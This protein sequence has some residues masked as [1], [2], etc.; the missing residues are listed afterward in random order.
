MA[1]NSDV[2]ADLLKTD[3]GADAAGPGFLDLPRAMHFWM[4]GEWPMLA[5][6]DK[7][8]I[9][10]DRDRGLTA[11][12]VAA[13]HHFCDDQDAARDWSRIALAWGCP[14][15]YLL[16]VLAAGVEITV[17]R[18]AAITG[19]IDRARSRMALSAKPVPGEL[20]QAHA[21][22]R[23]SKELAALGLLNESAEVIGEDLEKLLE[24]PLGR[25]ARHR[26]RILKSE[27][28]QVRQQ[29]ALHVA[30]GQLDS[31]PSPDAESAS[32]ADAAK[33]HSM[34]QLG[35][36][37]WVLEHTG[38]KRG[39]YFVEFG[40]T[41]GV[42]L[43]NTFLLEK[44]FGWSG[45][46]AEPN[47][48][49]F[50]DLKKNRSSKALDACIAGKSGESVEFVLADEFGGIKDYIG[51]DRH[52]ARREA[53]A[54]VPENV[55]KLETISLDEFLAANGAPRRIDYISVDT[56]GNELDILG[57][58]PFEKWDVALWTVEHNFTNERDEIFKIMASHGYM[59]KEVRFDDW[60]YKADQ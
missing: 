57:A 15:P 29:L 38:Y 1:T 16:R 59:R 33:Q 46:L 19:D 30:R 23:L 52:A 31:R 5:A 13:A 41:D 49:Y 51:R 50:A 7:A 44:M 20:S 2:A 39:G 22:A 40:A 25:V 53:Y 60:Y 4:G 17:A 47:P 58:F 43:S 6:Q 9:T 12:F 3:G 48:N 27:L 26:V 37:L 32:E 56:E 36:D 34:S 35:Q 42:L 54:H 10:P 21:D 18:M 45:L 24:E 11:A 55:L 28:V 8:L 14:K